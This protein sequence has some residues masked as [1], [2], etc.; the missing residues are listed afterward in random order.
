MKTTEVQKRILDNLSTA[1][2]FVD[3][4]LSI[5]Y[6]NP[7]AEMLLDASARQ[8]RQRRLEEWFVID[9]EQL[10]I[11]RDSVKTGHPYTHREEKLVNFSGRQLTVDYTV[12]HFP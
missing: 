7:A 2:I 6:L 11:L 5:R 3:D 8:I 4:S 12:N 9:H 1:V 10:A